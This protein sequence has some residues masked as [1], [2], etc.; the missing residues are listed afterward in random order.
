[1]LWPGTAKLLRVIRLWLLLAWVR[2]GIWHVPCTY[3]SCRM[4]H[5]CIGV[6][7]LLGRI[8]W[9]MLAWRLFRYKRS[10]VS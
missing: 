7:P 4:S 3:V 6:V 8:G 10:T 2:G 5:A 1:M 9:L